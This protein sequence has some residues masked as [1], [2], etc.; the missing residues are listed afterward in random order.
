MRFINLSGLILA[1]ITVVSA[2]N[3]SCAPSSGDAKVLELAWGISDFLSGFY[4]NTVNST[5]SPTSSNASIVAYQRVLLGVEKD[6][7]LGIQAIEKVGAKAPGFK[8]LQCDYTYP[9]VSGPSAWAQWS[10]RFESTLTGAFIGLAGYTQSP[11]VSF[12]LARL[13][14]EHSAHAT[15]I[16]GRVNSTLFA[17]NTTSLVSAYG[18]NQVLSTTNSTGSLGQFLGGCLKAPSSPCGTENI[19]PLVATITPSSA[20]GSSS[21]M[22]SSTPMSSGGSSSTAASSSSTAASSTSS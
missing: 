9:T 4:N 14:A 1:G 18:P 5:F 16:G 2:A 10:Y 22:A 21:A 7:Q 19:G 20:A 6:N 8:A 17:S 13:A 3:S 15:L 11:E 12:L